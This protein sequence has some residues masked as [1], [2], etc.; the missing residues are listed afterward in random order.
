M[1]YY[2]KPLHLQPCFEALGHG[3]GDFPE[4][5]R[6]AA[7]VLAIPVFPE[8]DMDKQAFIVEQIRD[9]YGL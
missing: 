2:P 5:E 4:A 1:V 7:E 8:L 9:F 3:P 6:A